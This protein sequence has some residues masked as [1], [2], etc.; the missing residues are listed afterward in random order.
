MFVCPIT[1]HKVSP[2][3]INGNLIS[4]IS[5]SGTEYKVK[6][7]IPNFYVS[8]SKNSWSEY[9]AVNA[10]NY[11]NYNHTTFE[12]QGYDEY[13]VRQQVVNLLELKNEDKI[14]E[15]GCG[16]GRDSILIAKEAQKVNAKLHC[17]DA[18]FPMISK[19]REKL[20][21]MSLDYIIYAVA[22]GENIPFEDNYFDHFFSFVA[23]SPVSNKEKCLREIARVVKPGGKVIL[24]SE[25][26]LPSLKKQDF[27][28]KIINNCNLYNDNP[29]LD[30]LPVEARNVTL[31]WI[32][33][34]IIYILQF[35][36]NIGEIQG[37]FDQIIGGKRGGSINSRYYGNLVGV[38]KETKELFEKVMAKN[39]MSKYDW[40]NDV[41]IKQAL[42]DIQK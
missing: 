11:D 31:K 28:K 7:G 8:D 32:L 19:C 14:L 6:E 24:V 20:N 12:L 36:I 23:F 42:I 4:Y 39:E 3:I 37:N 35:D 16:T 25:G 15:L 2:N 5:D 26:L 38:S 10:E 1:K 21:G 40:L 30:I 41:I 22:N 33:N 18:S 27:G 9:Y 13:T 29:P 17:I 34:G